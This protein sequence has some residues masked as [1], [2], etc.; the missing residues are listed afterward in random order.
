M[1]TVIECS[2]AK[3][4]AKGFSSSQIL[5]KLKR[6]SEIVVQAMKRPHYR[7]TMRDIASFVCFTQRLGFSLCDHDAGRKI[8]RLF[9]DLVQIHVSEGAI[10]FRIPF[11]GRSSIS[12]D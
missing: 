12:Q 3:A 11:H 2:G 6:L 5:P 1:V 8:V 10:G 9:H 7:H 4:A